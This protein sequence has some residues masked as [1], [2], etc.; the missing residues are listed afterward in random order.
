MGKKSTL[1]T[2]EE[3]PY[4]A[5]DNNGMRLPYDPERMP[6]GLDPRIWDL[7]L[8]FED[9]LEQN[10]TSAPGRPVIYVVL[11]KRLD[12][13]GLDVLRARARTDGIAGNWVTLVK[14]AID[15]YFNLSSIQFSV[16]RF[17]DLETFEYCMQYATDS[18]ERKKLIEE[19][20]KVSQEDRP[21]LPSRRT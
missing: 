12:K 2:T 20:D 5:K 19:G 8:Y 3:Y 15:V 6:E 11:S 16:D 17:T 14:A 18:F 4:V 10:R 1:R 21:V 13:T 7:T 9:K